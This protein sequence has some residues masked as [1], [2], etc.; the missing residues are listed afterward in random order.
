MKKLCDELNTFF[1]R[2]CKGST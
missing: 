1:H 2:W